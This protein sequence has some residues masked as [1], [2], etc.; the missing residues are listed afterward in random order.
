MADVVVRQVRTAGE[1]LDA[2]AVRRTVFIVEQG[3]PE[4]IERDGSDE[5][6]DHVVAYVGGVAAGAGRLVVDGDVARVGR[7]AVRSAVRGQGIGSMLLRALEDIAGMRGCAQVELHAQLHAAPFYRQLGY[8]A[9]GDV[10]AEAGIEH[11]AM[12]KLLPPR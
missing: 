7:M 3:V 10:F 8:A 1:L 12:R 2:Y 4:S 11:V 5:T 9:E 6:A